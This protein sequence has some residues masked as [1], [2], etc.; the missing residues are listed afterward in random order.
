[1][2]VLNITLLGSFAVH[3]DEVDVD[4]FSTVKA[5]AL[6][7]YLAIEGDRPLD[8]SHL[9]EVFWPDRLEESARGSLR[10]ALSNLRKILGDKK[11][12][13]PYLLIT[14]RMVQLHPDA[15]AAG[16]IQ[17]DVDRFQ[18][19]YRKAGTEPHVAGEAIALYRGPFFDNNW[20]VDSPDFD[21]WVQLQREILH[22]QMTELLSDVYQQV[23]QN[24]EMA[25]AVQ[26]AQRQVDHD[27]WREEAHAQLMQ[28]L[29]RNGQADLAMRQY[30]QCRRL[31]RDELD[32]EPSPETMALYEE[33]RDRRRDFQRPTAIQLAKPSSPSSARTKV[34]TRKEK[35][36]PP[37]NIPPLLKPFFGREQ[38]LAEIAERLD[39]PTCRQLT[40]TGPGGMGKTQLALEYARR[41]LQSFPDGVWFVSLGGVTD[42]EQIPA[43]II[44]SLGIPM[45]PEQ[46]PMTRLCQYLRERALLLILDNF[47]HLRDHALLL[48]ELLQ[49]AHQITILVT[50]RER[51]NLQIETV[52]VLG[53]LDLPQ[54]DDPTESEKD[55]AESG[56]VALFVDCAQRAD[57]SFTLTSENRAA[58]VDI[59]HLTD[60]MPL[61]IELAAVW[62]R[63][64]SCQ[65]I[66]QNLQQ[67]MDLL[68][69]TM[70]DIP[71]RHRCMRV[72][73]EESWLHLTAEAQQIFAQTSIFR[74]G[75]DWPALQEVTQASMLQVVELVDRGFLQRMADGSY[76]THELMR[77][78]GA[79][80]LSQ[81]SAEAAAVAQCH[82]HHYLH[83]LGQQETALIGHEQVV[84]AQKIAVAIENIRVAWHWAL[85]QSDTP[86]LDMAAEALFKYYD[87]RGLAHEGAAIFEHTSDRL[88]QKD[89]P[90]AL[91]V[92]VRNYLGAFLELLGRGEEAE[93]LLTQ[94]LA[95]AREH[96]LPNATAWA[97]L[98][99][100]TIV[101]WNDVNRAKTMLEESR[102]LFQ[103]IK[104][105][106]GIIAAMRRLWQFIVNREPDKQPALAL[107]KEILQEARDLDAPLLIANSLAQVGV[108]YMLLEQYEQARFYQEEALTLARLLKNRLLEAEY[109]N[110]LA[111][112]AAHDGD[113]L[114]SLKLLEES[115]QLYQ[116]IGLE[117]GE[118]LSAE[119]NLGRLAQN[120]EEWETALV[121]FEQTAAKCRRANNQF[122]LG[123][124]YEGL[125][126]TRYK[127]GDYPQARQAL[128][129][130]I[131]AKDLWVLTPARTRIQQTLIQ[132]LIAEEAYEAAA[133]VLAFKIQHYPSSP[134][135]TFDDGKAEAELRNKIG[136]KQ[137]A[138]IAQEAPQRDID[139]LIDTIL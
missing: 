7:A 40:V 99:L 125:A 53:G 96:N 120:M 26:V 4:R 73:F 61:G 70:P 100:G 122:L 136:D 129:L 77:Q 33:I 117:S 30:E 138:V 12:E 10:H 139:E 68:T 17:V 41:E 66:L 46:E 6:L 44:D 135:A 127:L 16:T 103:Q 106:E 102:D 58:V 49:E 24:G 20:V 91:L 67:S 123:R 107:A 105:G 94:N 37:H 85:E 25:Q 108:S 22:R 81:S 83:F 104:D 92:R 42:D 27:P 60:G 56:A 62:T 48:P 39:L 84:V 112:S 97:L 111:V 31:L 36:T 98:R 113:K 2:P 15:L 64:L 28:A 134:D 131:E 8:R 95:L 115:V 114:R 80:K 82:A 132:V 45:A 18:A 119:E 110:G 1:M 101:A 57:T 87:S 121:H 126:Y 79:E 69:V 3:I 86:L 32:V 137:Y 133:W 109:L 23:V 130:A 65:E 5:R 43:T 35:P 89:P 75:C 34:E 51:L 47:E 116:Q 52:L 50:S 11:I 29:W 124:C 9:A 71:P 88:S 59:C 72:L 118:A 128:C 90:I 19:L 93:V 74:G 78:F 13:P 38:E 55:G 63:L 76:Q 14:R 54:I 21:R